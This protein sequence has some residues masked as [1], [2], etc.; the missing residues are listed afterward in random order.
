MCQDTDVTDLVGFG[1]PDDELLPLTE[2]VCGARF[3]MWDMVISIYREDAYECDKCGRRLY[4]R[5]DIKVY[6]VK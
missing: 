2:C 3:D 1:N 4:F 5:N 6:E